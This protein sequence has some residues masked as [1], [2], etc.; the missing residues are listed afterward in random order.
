[1]NTK[2]TDEILKE[3]LKWQKLHGTEIL[4]KKIEDKKLFLDDNQILAYYHSDGNRS[5]RDIAKIT[6]IGYK[7]IQ[8]LWKKW[9]LA[10]IAEPS[11]KYG[12]GQCKRLFELHELSLELPKTKKQDNKND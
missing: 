7:T 2:P 11:E 4:K 6:G 12:G 9:I 1:M 3:I 10:G 5:S 8:T